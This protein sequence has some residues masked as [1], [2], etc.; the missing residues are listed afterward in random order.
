[1]FTDSTVLFF[2]CVD[3]R[4]DLKPLFVDIYVFVDVDVD[5]YVDVFVDVDRIR[6]LPPWH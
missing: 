6:L 5:V 2:L 3:V 4:F 1:V